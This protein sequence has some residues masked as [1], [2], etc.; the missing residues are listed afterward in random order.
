MTAELES[1]IYLFDHL[2]SAAEERLCVAHTDGDTKRMGEEQTKLREAT[3]HR[4][5]CGQQLGLKQ[6]T[7]ARAGVRISDK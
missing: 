7:L 5:Y 2:I 1:E 4:Y 3:M 6:N